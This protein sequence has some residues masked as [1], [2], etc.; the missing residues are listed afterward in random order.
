VHG[1]VHGDRLQ[2]RRRR[3]AEGDFSFTDTRKETFSG[4]YGI[5]PVQTVRAG[6]LVAPRWGTH[7]WGWL[8]ASASAGTAAS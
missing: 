3:A 2:P 5:T 6:E 7:P 4:R 1:E 8:P